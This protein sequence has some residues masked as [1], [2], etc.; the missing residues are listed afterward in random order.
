MVTLSALD[1]Y[2]TLGAWE[3]GVVLDSSG[4]VAP[5]WSPD[6]THPQWQHQCALW[7]CG[8]KIVTLEASMMYTFKILQ[9]VD[10]KFLFF[11]S[12][13]PLA[14]ELP[15]FSFSK[16]WNVHIFSTAKCLDLQISFQKGWRF[17]GRFIP[18]QRLPGKKTPTTNRTGA[19]V[20]RQRFDGFLGGQGVVMT[21]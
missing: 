15:S 7:K 17:C 13:L 3:L 10:W 16:N 18:K 19:N 6:G 1:S 8:W 20:A 11:E 4:R 12:F 21:F 2:F 5:L 14:L 9:V